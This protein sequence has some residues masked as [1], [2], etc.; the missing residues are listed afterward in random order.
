MFHYIVNNGVVGSTHSWRTDGSNKRVVG[1]RFVGDPP[2]STQLHGKTAKYDIQGK[3]ERVTYYK[4]G[5]RHGLESV[6]KNGKL[7][8]L[9]CRLDGKQIWQRSGYTFNPA[10]PLTAEQSRRSCP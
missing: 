6:Y 8:V 9:I 7:M 5:K 3:P 1:R 4:N 2:T 10:R